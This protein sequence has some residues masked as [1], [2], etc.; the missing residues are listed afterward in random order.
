MKNYLLLSIFIVFTLN[1]SSQGI[2]ELND[3]PRKTMET[4]LKYLQKDNFKP[5]FSA[6]TLNISNSGDKHSQEL[7]I[8]LKK[9]L[10]ARGLFVIIEDIPD[11][12]NY[13]DKSHKKHLFIPFKSVP[14]I[15]LRKI[16]KNWLYS[17][18]TINNIPDLYSETFPLEATGFKKLIPDSL[19]SNV[20]GM[21]L[22]KYVG[23]L[24]FIILA[25]IIYKIISWIIEYFLLRILKKALKNSPIVENYIEPIAH[26]ISFLLIIL[27]LSALL[28]L[29]EIPISINVWVAN[30]VKAL[31]PITI[32]LIVYRSSDLIADFYSVLASRTDTTVDDQLIPLV[33]KVIKIIIVILGLLYVLSV[34]G[35]EITPLLA[36]AS[37][38][39]LALALAAQDTLKNFFGS[40]T[41]YTDSPFEVGD[42]IVFD[43]GEGVVE[44]IRVRSTR[45]RTFHNSV[46]SVPNGILADLKIDNMGRRR[47]RRFRTQIGLTY[48]TPP[49][50][51]DAYV[52]GLRGIVKE[53]PKTKNDPY[54]IHLNEFGPSSLNILVYIFFEVENW[55]QELKARQ[56]FILEAIRLANELGVRFAFPTTTLHVEEMPGQESL[57][58]KYSDT[59]ETFFNKATSF[60]TGRKSK[61]KDEFN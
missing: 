49:D 17:K 7:A 41:I 45:L 10:D 31:V 43:G 60:V 19:K 6:K 3:T 48:D 35:V 23:L 34:L 33:R 54:E 59:K 22:W 1:L 16:D 12:I 47:L 39:G 20:L 53:H 5:E 44:E 40:I 14:E 56:E 18:E 50:L 32:T 30:T 13:K 26:P 58:P 4:H 8:K 38:G 55:T 61:Y 46:I 2:D 52:T 24:I 42:W 27:L 28:P 37:V 25:L 57:T 51:I 21:A 11:D 29:L 9:I 36:G 15:Y